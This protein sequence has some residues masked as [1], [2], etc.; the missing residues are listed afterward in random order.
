MRVRFAQGPFA[1]LYWTFGAIGP[2]VA[3]PVGTTVAGVLLGL[4]V[5]FVEIARQ[6]G[7]WVV[8]PLSFIWGLVFSM[9]VVLSRGLWRLARWWTDWLNRRRG[10]DLPFDRD[11][12]LVIR[13]SAYVK[14]VLSTRFLLAAF[15]LMTGFVVALYSSD[16]IVVPCIISAHLD[17]TLIPMALG[18]CGSIGLNQRSSQLIA[19]FSITLVAA[20]P[21]HGDASWIVGWLVARID[22]RRMATVAVNDDATG[23]S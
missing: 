13:P 11:A 4:T 23:Q 17:V 19:F 6:D 7:M 18:I 14:Y 16:A 3:L 1:G 22:R 9:I 20:C 8:V 12:T 2:L 15:I 21:L 5:P 10:G